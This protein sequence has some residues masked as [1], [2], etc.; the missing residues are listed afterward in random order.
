[1]ALDYPKTAGPAGTGLQHSAVT[2]DAPVRRP[3]FRRWRLAFGALAIL[4]ALFLLLRLIK[5]AADDSPAGRPGAGMPI[6]VNVAKA[7]KGDV[8]VILDALGTVTPLQTVTVRTQISGQLQQIAFKEGQMVK[9]GEFIAQID[10]RPYQNALEQAEGQMAHDQALLHDAQLDLQR[11]K[12]LVAQDSIAHQQLDTQAALVQQYQATIVT[13]QAAIDTAKLN[14]A[15]C[16]IVSPV[17]G[18]IG[19]R[20]VDQGNYVTPSDANGLVVITQLQPMSVVFTLPEDNVLQVTKPTHAGAFLQATAFDRN[21][22]TQLSVGKLTNIDNQ[23]D[24]TTGTFKLRAEFDNEDES[25]F[26]NQFVNIKLLVDTIHDQTIVP[27]SS[28]QH[29]A[30]GAFVYLVNPDST[31]SVRPVKLGVT[32]G[33]RQGIV[34]GLTPGDTVVTDGVDRLRDGAKIVLPGAQPPQGGPPTGGHRRHSGAGQDGQA[35]NAGGP[36]P[37]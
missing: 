5:P 11:Y 24:T 17:T 22:T 8:Q 23:I 19:L 7:D 28:I 1:M 13:D 15:Y 36:P 2:A 34:S 31:V 18:R 6:S 29:G 35:G 10:P 16:H 37:K 20:Q 12:T 30:P 3:F 27:S 32:D 9:Q 14:L 25:L 33:E 21:N 26:P 4:L